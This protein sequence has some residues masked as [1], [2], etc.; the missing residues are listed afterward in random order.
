M[1]AGIFGVARSA[2]LGTYAQL[3]TT[4]HNIANVNTPG[5]SRQSVI[6]STAG[7]NYSGGGFLGRGV[8][9]GDVRRRSDEFVNH[10]VK[11][12]NAIAGADKARARELDRIQMLFADSDTGIGAA[13]DDWQ[14]AMADF[15]N[16]PSNPSVRQAVLTRADTMI[17]R[18]KNVDDQLQ[19][20]SVS[21]NER[22]RKV[23]DDLSTKLEQLG[24]L[25]VQ[26]ARATGAAQSPNDLFDQRDLIVSQIN[27]SMRVNTFYNHDG[28]VNVTTILGQGLLIGAN[29][30]KVHTR[31]D[32]ADPQLQQVVIDIAG[33]ISALDQGMLAGGELAGLLRARDE[34][35]PAARA[36]VGQMVGGLAQAYNQQ[37]ALGI[38]LNGNPGAALFS[39][40]APQA[41]A[42]SDN[43]GTAV[44][45]LAISDASALQASDYTLSFDG[46][47]YRLLRQG[48]GVERTYASLPTTVDGFTIDVSGAPSTNDRFNLR[49]SSQLVNGFGRILSAPSALAGA[50][51]VTPQ[52]DGA[53]SGDGSVLDF[54]VTALDADLGSPVSLTFTSANS[55]DV[56]GSGTG[57]PVNQTYVPGQPISFNGWTLRL[58][59]QPKPGDVFT[60]GATASP[61]TD[62]RNARALLAIGRQPVVNGLS[63]N[64]AYAGIVADI[65]IRAQGAEAA[66][67]QSERV[68]ENA[69]AAQAEISG[70]NLDEEAALILQYQ[71]AYQAAAKLMSTVQNMFDTLIQAM[72]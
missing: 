24:H 33:S 49:V 15:A 58:A 29:V 57:D 71:Q 32:P 56:V 39:I 53:N 28:T 23:S 30:A 26:I 38:D 54:S 62:N 34:D 27:E 10:E 37:Q 65:G 13:Y 46:A 19:S 60:I 8:Q 40:G 69:K 14:M 3:Q 45:D 36:L 66:K 20:F 70:V 4:G 52:A 31:N 67:V 63:I 22:L 6:L 48:D 2:L 12:A 17:S 11:L 68:L 51:P 16:E 41:L 25:N 18:I 44:I 5:Y 43:T 42:S 61:A 59:G 1:T 72:G 64:D 47:Q 55:F 21:I 50:L 9:I 7:G 35:L